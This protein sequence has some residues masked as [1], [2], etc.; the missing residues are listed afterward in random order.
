VVSSFCSGRERWTRSISY[1][2][3]I[4]GIHLQ[5]KTLKWQAQLSKA[6]R[7]KGKQLNHETLLSLV[8][9]IVR[10]QVRANHHRSK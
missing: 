4:Q 5:L 6:W 10:G 9:T 7:E 8:A 3:V 1:E 2:G